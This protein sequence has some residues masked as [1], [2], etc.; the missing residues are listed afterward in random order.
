MREL[1]TLTPTGDPEVDDA[2]RAG[3]QT[4][5]AA[6]VAEQRTKTKLLAEITWEQ[7]NN[8][9]P[10][11]VV[12]TRHTLPAIRPVNHLVDDGGVII[13]PRLSAKIIDAVGRDTDAPG[14][15][16]AYQP[17]LIDPV[18][19]LGWSVTVTDLARP[20]TDRPASPV[21]AAPQPWVDHVMDT[22]IGIRPTSSPG[23]A[24][25]S[26]AAPGSH[27]ALTV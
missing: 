4:C 21:R 6:N 14:T 17:D 7:Q 3:I 2:W 20:I 23:S 8:T 15:M 22:V 12:F 25:C 10:R 13:R 5:F 26:R 9:P 24:W 27:R 19:R 18:Q 11:R 16:V 1:E